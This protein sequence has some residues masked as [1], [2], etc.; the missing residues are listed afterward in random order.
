MLRPLTSTL[1]YDETNLKL[2]VMV[3]FI[4]SRSVLFLKW[5]AE[6]FSNVLQCFHTSRIS[7]RKSDYF[8]AD[9]VN[10]TE[11]PF[12]ILGFS[13]QAKPEDTIMDDLEVCLQLIIFWQLLKIQVVR[14]WFADPEL[15][16]ESAVW[17]HDLNDVVKVI[18]PLPCQCDHKKLAELVVDRRGVERVRIRYEAEKSLPLGNRDPMVLAQQPRDWTLKRIE[19]CKQLRDAYCDCLAKMDLDDQD[20]TPLERQLDAQGRAW[21][22]RRLRSIVEVLENLQNS[23]QVC[24]FSCPCAEY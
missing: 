20:R 15:P 14:V 9:L 7:H 5:P 24:S 13:A 10:Y 4:W 6:L 21:L 8:G 22:E 18:V 12:G 1:L 19:A 2:I 16:P 11:D 23:V 17:H 3:F